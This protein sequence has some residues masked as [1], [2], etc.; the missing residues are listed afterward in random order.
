MQIQVHNKH[1]V[2]RFCMRLL[3]MLQELACRDGRSTVLTKHHAVL[4]NSSL[5]QAQASLV[6]QMYLQVLEDQQPL[7][8]AQQEAA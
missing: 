1:A 7:D 8:S 3:L 6:Q 2:V 5:P 4:S